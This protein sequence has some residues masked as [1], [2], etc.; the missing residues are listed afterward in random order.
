MI[1]SI[2]IALLTTL[3][4]S[5]SQTSAA[6]KTAPKAAEKSAEV[7]SK[8]TRPAASSAGKRAAPKDGGKIAG[9]LMS[10]KDG[11]ISVKADGDDESEKYVIDASNK[12]L[13]ESLKSIFD[14]ARVQLTYKQDGDTRTLLSIKKQVVKPIGTITGEVVKVH[15]N[16]WVEVKPKN[17][18]PDAFAPG[19]NYNDK[20]FMELLRGLKP[21]ETVTISYNTDFE[22]HRITSLRKHPASRP[23]TEDSKSTTEPAKK[24]S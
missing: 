8:S 3:F 7:D 15:N 19:A 21:G 20:A 5:A 23:K 22:R 12:K 24:A 14:A 1:K 11:A 17:A 2:L 18:V 13:I 6:D 16:F 9:I 10:K 4:W